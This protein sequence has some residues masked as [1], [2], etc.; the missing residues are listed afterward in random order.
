MPTALRLFENSWRYIVDGMNEML[1]WSADL[2]CDYMNW[3]KAKVSFA[4]VTIADDIEKRQV[5]LQY[6]A[7]QKVSDIT[8][9]KPFGIDFE[10]EQRNLAYQNK[11]F[12][13]V[14]KEFQ[15][16]MKD[17]SS[18]AGN[19]Q[20][21]NPSMSPFDFVQQAEMTAQN[22]LSMPYEI[23]KSQ[24][25]DMKQKNPTLHALV[26]TKM[27]DFRSKMRT[28]QGNN[29][30]MSQGMMPPPQPPQPPQ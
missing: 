20:A 29:A 10:D 14:Q 28:Q 13:E 15:K 23:R 1:Q 17:E 6:A 19:P 24:L 12:A 7:A 4:K 30:M 5:V 22:M 9:L 16:D 2:M 26:L 27:N 8:A 11:I 3:E 21:A 18:L 25:Y